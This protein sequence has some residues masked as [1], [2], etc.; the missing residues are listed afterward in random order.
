V[1][2]TARRLGRHV[3]GFVLS[4][5]LAAFVLAGAAGRAGGLGPIFPPCMLVVGLMLAIQVRG[6][7][8]TNPARALA[9]FKT[10]TWVGLAVFAAFALGCL[11]VNSGF[12]TPG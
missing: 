6:M 2:S 5:Y 10:N 12:T 11:R 7:R 1:K 4:A 3:P 8:N 9:A